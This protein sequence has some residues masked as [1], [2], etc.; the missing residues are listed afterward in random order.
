MKSG[1]VRK[2]EGT[3][4]VLVA[5]LLVV[6]LGMMALAVD[7]SRLYVVRQFLINSCDASALAGG[8]ELP[9]QAKSTEKASECAEANSMTAYQVSFPADGFTEN[10]ATKIRVDGE[11][12][13][14]YCFANILGFQSRVVSAYAVVTRNNEI[15]WVNGIAI[16]WGIP[17]YDR[18]GDPYEYDNGVLYTLK[19]GSQS[20]LA[21]GSV[22]KVGG[23]FYPL[24]LDRSLGEGASGGNV[25]RD[26][27][28][29]GFDGQVK[30]GDITSTEPG[31]MVGPTR[32]SVI[33]DDDSLIKRASVEP[34]AD[35]T[36]DNYDYG[37]PRIV[38]VPIISPLG[39]GRLDV[40]ILGFASF[41]VESMQSQTVKG[42]F[43]SYTIPGAGG[44]GPDY[45][46]STFLLTE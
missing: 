16:P 39:N 1:K 8:I 13:V 32:Q 23:N 24:A 3:V 15:G 36:W 19:T 38:I 6:L 27:V 31:N 5:V 9:D 11:L 46:L 35:D 7:I 45:G 18:S 42:Y 25:Y 28:K 44:S 14:N 43:L 41:W 4:L 21:N 33:S 34:W 26:D 29:W 37:N 30:V 12:N 17:Y 2:H 10:G 40:E 22:G 20:D